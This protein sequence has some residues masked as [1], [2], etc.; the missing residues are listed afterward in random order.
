M[1]LAVILIN[2]AYVVLLGSTF[3]RTLNWLRLALIS[4]SVLFIAYGLLEGIRSMVIWNLVTGTLHTTRIIKDL[5]ARRS[6]ALTAEEAVIRD[7]SFPGLDD[8]DFNALWSLGRPYNADGTAFIEQ[9]SSPDHVMLLMT[10]QVRVERDG[11]VIG[12]LGRGSLVG[13]MSFASGDPANASVIAD[14]PVSM[15]GWTQRDLGMLAQLNPAS[16]RAF[17]GLMARDLTAK[18]G[19]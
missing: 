17:D 8:F 2:G 4:G 11:G 16:A 6:V 5:R 1:S 3:T 19:S 12:T 9:G 13:E 10:G 7:Q 15:H 14:G 18:V